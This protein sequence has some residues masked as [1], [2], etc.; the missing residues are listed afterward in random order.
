MQDNS[1]WIRES[2]TNVGDGVIFLAMGYP[3]A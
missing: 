3:S 1:G 2:V